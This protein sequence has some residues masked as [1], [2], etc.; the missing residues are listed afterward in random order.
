VVTKAPADRDPARPDG[1]VLDELGDDAIVAQ[2]S[3][4]HAPQRR[5]QVAMEA[6]SVVIAADAERPAEPLEKQ[7]PKFAS[8]NEPTLVIRDRR[9]LDQLSKLSFPPEPPRR[10]LTTIVIWF[11]AAVLALGFGGI[12]ALLMRQRSSPVQKVEPPPVVAQVKPA[13]L[14]GPATSGSP[15]RVETPR[16][17][18]GEPIDLDE[19]EHVSPSELPIE[20]SSSAAK[21]RPKKPAAPKQTS[22]DDIPSGI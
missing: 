18:A 13:D 15:A 9:M 21:P 5:V 20:P 3:T 1:E 10:R 11:A 6:R 4:P 16:A 14:P 17:T 8:S 22:G 19:P 7:F 2:Q 12:L